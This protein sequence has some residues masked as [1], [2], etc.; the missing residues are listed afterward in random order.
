M[1]CIG[2]SMMCFDVLELWK[3]SWN[4]SGSIWDH[5]FF[6]I[7]SQTWNTLPQGLAERG[8]KH[9]SRETNDGMHENST[10]HRN[11]NKFVHSNLM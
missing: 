6:I 5:S 8:A 3:P 10:T 7:F 2:C 11:D 1:A 4:D 9:S